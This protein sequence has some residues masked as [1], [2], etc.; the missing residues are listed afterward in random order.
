[1]PLSAELVLLF[2]A[3]RRRLHLV[4]SYPIPRRLSWIVS[5]YLARHPLDTIV[6]TAAAYM[7]L[8]P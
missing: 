2:T 4:L 7:L 8:K 6:E 3:V 1:M 5:R